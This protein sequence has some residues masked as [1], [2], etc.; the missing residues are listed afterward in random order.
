[1]DEE[2]ARHLADIEALPLEV[3][4]D[5]LIAVHDELLARLGAA[6]SAAKDG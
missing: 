4:A 2:L 5:A 1:M 3:R 6:D